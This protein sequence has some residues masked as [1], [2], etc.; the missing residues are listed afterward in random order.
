[1]FSKS[2]VTLLAAANFFASTAMAAADSAGYILPSSGSASTTQFIL[3]SELSS[4]TACGVN[5]LPGGVSTSG[6]QGGGPGM[7][8]VSFPL[9]EF[10]TF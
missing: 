2:T 1:M 5:A 7:L 10:W 8:Y 4:G 3:G 6:G 9:S